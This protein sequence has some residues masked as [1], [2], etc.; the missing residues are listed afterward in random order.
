MRPLSPERVHRVLT[1]VAVI[2]ALQRQ[3]L[4]RRG[5]TRVVLPPQ[6]HDDD[7]IVTPP[8][9]AIVIIVIVVTIIDPEHVDDPTFRYPPEPAFHRRPDH[10]AHHFV[11]RP[12]QQIVY[13]VISLLPHYEAR[14]R[15]RPAP[16]VVVVAVLPEDDAV[17]VALAPGYNGFSIPQSQ[18]A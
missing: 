13:P 8:L 7:R 9:P 15:R 16:A 17:V 5:F 1:S 6:P 2:H 10:V 12:L 3:S 14:A 11:Q 4:R 18:A